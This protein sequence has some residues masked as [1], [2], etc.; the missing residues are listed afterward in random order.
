MSIAT[1]SSSL[2]ISVFR[3]GSKFSSTSKGISCSFLDETSEYLEIVGFKSSRDFSNSDFSFLS[4]LKEMVFVVS[5]STTSL[6]FSLFVVVSK[7]LVS[8]SLAV[9]AASLFC[10]ILFISASKLT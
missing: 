4:F 6:V 1:V 7:A 9:F 8:A 10:L 3:T 2:A 5:V